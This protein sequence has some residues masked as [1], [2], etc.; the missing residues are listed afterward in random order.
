[1]SGAKTRKR[2]RAV[3]ATDSDWQTVQSGIAPPY[4]QRI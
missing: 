3:M 4:F 1:M 2:Q